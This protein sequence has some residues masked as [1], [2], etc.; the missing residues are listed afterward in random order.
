MKITYFPLSIRLLKVKFL[1]LRLVIPNHPSYF[2]LM[3]KFESMSLKVEV[4]EIE[5]FLFHHVSEV[6]IFC[7]KIVQLRLIL[8]F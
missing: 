6:M 1:F 8:R 2:F 4:F 7:L 5:V 3:S